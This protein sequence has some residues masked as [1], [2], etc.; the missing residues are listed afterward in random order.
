MDLA[1][2]KLIISGGAGFLG[3]AI[4]RRLVGTGCA[5]TVVSR[6]EQKH[7]RLRRDH[8][9]VETRVCDVRDREQLR[10][11]AVGHDVGIWAASMKQ[12]DECARN[13]QMAKEIILD[14]AINARRVSE[15][16]LEAAVFVSTD[17]AKA[18]S[19]LYGLLKGAAG[20]SFIIHPRSCRLT[21]AV[22]GNVWNSTGSIIPC[23]WDSVRRR[24]E[25]TLHAEEMTRF[26]I[27]VDHAVDVLLGALDHTGCYVVPRL[28]AFRVLDLFELYRERFGLR[29]VLG[30]PRAAEKIHEVM[31]TADEL[32]RMRWVA[33]GGRGVYL[34]EPEPVKAPVSFPSGEYCSRDHVVD[35]S[36]LR[37]ILEAA[38]YF[39]PGPDDA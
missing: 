8:P 15:E 27:D 39:E 26:M 31:A 38:R 6:D 18:P 28:D 35:K 16:C 20:A 11:H 9:E 5:I 37:E 4:V 3:R 33:G 24:R 1:G 13:W 22:Y 29:F 7:L 10:R 23:I 32:P 2:K 25:L 34:I 30:Q 21:A 14:G 36:E 12:I 17:E 19:T